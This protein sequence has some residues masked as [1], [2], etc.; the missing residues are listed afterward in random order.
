METVAAVDT[1][2]RLGILSRMA[3][4]PRTA[5]EVAD[6]LRLDPRGVGRLLDAL[7]RIGLLHPAGRDSFKA[8]PAAVRCID[9]IAGSWA[10]L[11]MV[12]RT[13]APTTKANTTDG[14]GRLYPNT[15]ALL[16]AWFTPAATRLAELISPWSGRILDVGA[17]AAPWSIAIAAGNGRTRVTAVDVPEVLPATRRAVDHNGLANHSATSPVTSSPSTYRRR[18]TTC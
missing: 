17:G 1:A 12:L 16:A 15:V 8:D 13:G 11:P 5:A 7:V 14:A 10:E 6:D 4:S 18:P 9:M 3:T 2:R